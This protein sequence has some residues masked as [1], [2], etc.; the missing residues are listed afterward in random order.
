MSGPAFSS[1]DSSQVSVSLRDDFEDRLMANIARS[2]GALVGAVAETAAAEGWD[3]L[4]VSGD[5][6]LTNEFER[7]FELAGKGV[8]LVRDE[9]VWE[10]LPPMKWAEGRLRS[11][12]RLNGEKRPP[13]LPRLSKTQHSRDRRWWA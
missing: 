9:H 3:L 12:R 11:W 4:V 10:I 5:P 13:S 1:P 8:R 6:R 7:S 2:I